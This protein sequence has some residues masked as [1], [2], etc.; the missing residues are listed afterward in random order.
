MDNVGSESYVLSHMWSLASIFMF[1]YLEVI[2]H[3]GQETIKEPMRG[4]ER[5]CK[6]GG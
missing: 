4:E 5:G 1:A 3:R 2:V 6:G